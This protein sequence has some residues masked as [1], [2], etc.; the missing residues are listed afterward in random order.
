MALQERLARLQGEHAALRATTEAAT[1]SAAGELAGLRATV[2][3]LRDELADLRSVNEVLRQQAARPLPSAGSLQH[4]RSV[5]LAAGAAP[6]EGG[7]E[8]ERLPSAAS[9][10]GSAQQPLG[11]AGRGR[12]S[13]EY[14][15]EGLLLPAGDAASA[16][17]SALADRERELAAARQRAEALE[18]EVA[19]LERE[20]SLRQAQ[21]QALKEAVRDLERE[22]ERQRLPGKQG[23]SGCAACEP[24]W[25]AV[26]AARGSAAGVVRCGCWGFGLSGTG[27][28]HC[29]VHPSLVQEQRICCPWLILWVLPRLWNTPAKPLQP[30][31]G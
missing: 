8:L 25:M 13:S 21:E 7:S 12:T 30:A 19:D 5:S 3:S 23:E 20:C 17:L 1:G 22:I 24:P 9:L 15:G 31:P 29:A 4:S 14:G 18:A 16:Q 28:L 10:A 11:L 6:S 2:A 27:Q 26:S